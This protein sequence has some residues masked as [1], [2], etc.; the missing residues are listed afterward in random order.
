[1]SLINLLLIFRSR[2]TVNCPSWPGSLHGDETDCWHSVYFSSFCLPGHGAAG[3]ILIMEVTLSSTSAA[4]FC[5]YLLAKRSYVICKKHWE[6]NPWPILPYL[7]V[8][9]CNTKVY[10]MIIQQRILDTVV[11]FLALLSTLDRICVWA[12]GALSHAWFLTRNILSTQNENDQ[13]F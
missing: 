12:S 9:Q 1:M 10:N 11:P 8:S 4:G 6:D 13:N 3:P 5:L 2:D 7:S